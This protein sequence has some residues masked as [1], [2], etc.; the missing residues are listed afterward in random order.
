[1]AC[2]VDEARHRRPLPSGLADPASRSHEG[3]AERRPPASTTRS[4]RSSSPCSVTTP[5]T[6]TRPSQS[7]AVTRPRTPAPRRISTPASAAARA[8]TASISGRRPVMARKRSSPGRGPPVMAAGN[9]SSGLHSR[10]PASVKAVATSGISARTVVVNRARKPCGRRNWLT[11]RRSHCSQARCGS[12]HPP[13]SR[14]RTVTSWP[15]RWRSSAP[16]RPTMPPPTIT[17]RAIAPHLR[18]SPTDLPARSAADPTPTP[19]AGWRCRAGRARALRR[20]PR[21]RSRGTLRQ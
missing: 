21:A 14:S 17:M 6:S 5:W 12:A 7:G 16:P 3:I 2:V 11:P 20:G 10:A 8:M 13:G 18:S 15:S 4:A 9:T 1:M 19:A